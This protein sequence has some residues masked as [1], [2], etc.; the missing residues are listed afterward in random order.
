MV[1]LDKKAVRRVRDLLYKESGGKPLT[2]AQIQ[3]ARRALASEAVRLGATPDV[4][5]A[6]TT[7]VMGRLVTASGKVKPAS[8]KK[9]KAKKSTV[10]QPA[11]ETL[12]QR[13]DRLIKENLTA[14]L[15]SKA[16]PGAGAGPAPGADGAAL[17]STLASEQ[18]SPFYRPPAGVSAASGNAGKGA[19]AVTDVEPAGLAAMDP[20]QLRSFA[21]GKFRE[22]A[23]AG[24]YGSPIWS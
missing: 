9:P 14:T 8:A 20:D 5:V 13:V 15:G 16:A 24:A 12:Q 2:A 23:T 10:K 11:A 4:A 1:K 17:M 22:F 7:A 19:V 3:A 6:E 21:A 18:R